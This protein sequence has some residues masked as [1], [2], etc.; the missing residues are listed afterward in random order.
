MNAPPPAILPI[1]GP[2]FLGLYGMLLAITTAWALLRRKSAFSRF[3]PAE[4]REPETV[5]QTAQLSAGAARVM[6]VAVLSLVARQHVMMRKFILNHRLVAIPGPQPAGDLGI[7][8]TRLLHDIKARGTGGLAFHE[9]RDTLTGPVAAIES[10][11][12]AFGLRPTAAEKN[13]AS[14]AAIMPLFLPL[15]LGVARLVTSLP[16]QKP[17]GWLIAMLVATGVLMAILAGTTGHLTTTGKRTL[18]V[19]RLRHRDLRHIH[20][21]PHPDDADGRANLLLALA[22]F[23]PAA[24]Q[25]IPGYGD[26]L[27]VAKRDLQDPSQGGGGVFSS[28]GCS[29]SGCSSGCGGGGGCGGCGGD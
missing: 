9:I 16:Q 19:L 12:A 2:E 6:L 13:R 22:L 14:R 17:V 24:V 7:E 23:G 10:R 1:S 20:Q 5:W 21:A 25:R 27:K 29:T 3:E 18:Q 28:S 11:L 26:I 4:A 8:E 15:G